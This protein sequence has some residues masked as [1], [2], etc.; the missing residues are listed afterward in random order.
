MGRIGTGERDAA[1][2]DV[3]VL[4]VHEKRLIR[5]ALAIALGERHIAVAG[6]CAPGA[7]A[8]TLALDGQVDVVVVGEG[9]DGAGVPFASEVREAAPFVRIVLVTSAARADRSHF[10][11]LGFEAVIGKH[12]GLA[13]FSDVI[14]AVADGIPPRARS[15][16]PVLGCARDGDGV[17][18]LMAST[19]TRREL[20]VLE[21]LADG[22]TSEQLSDEL[23]L[24]PHTVRTHIQN[25]MSK[26]Q[27]HSRLEAATFAVRHGIVVASGKDRM[28]G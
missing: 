10:D 3:H 16:A 14:R 2:P 22:A 12:L 19:L 11:G 23:S 18:Q 17:V 20:E 6:A 24:S 1:A 5:D 8:M 4:L 28:A 13:E 21:L 7:D 25:I 26:L 9:A 15:A 27:V